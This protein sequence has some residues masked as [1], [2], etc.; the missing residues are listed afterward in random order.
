[1]PEL[2]FEDHS[3]EVQ[4]ILGRIPKWIVRWGI[5]VLFSLVAIILVGGYF[6]PYPEKVVLPVKITT[7]NAPAPIVAQ[8]NSSRLAQWLVEDQ[9]IIE[10]GDLIGIWE[11][12]DNYY[13]VQLL[14]AAIKE[15]PFYKIVDTL[16]LPSFELEIRNHTTSCEQFALI[17][18]SNKHLREIDQLNKELT[19][20][21]E[22]LGLLR[23]QKQVKDREY[24]LL[25]KQFQQDSIYYY[26]GGYG[27][28][29][30]DYE[31]AL[32]LFLQQKSSYFQY[33]ASLVELS[34]SL[35]D[36]ENNITLVKEKREEQI[37]SAKAAIEEALFQIHTKIQDWE[38]ENL[39]VSPISG[40]LDRSQF[41]SKNQLITNGDV[42]AMVIP[43]DPIEIICR[44]IA[45]VQSIS[46]LKEGQRVLM[47][48][49]GFNAQQFGSVEGTINSIS[50]IPYG[51]DYQV[52]INLT[53]KL[54][55][56][57]NVEIPLIQGLTGIAEVVIDES[58]LINKLLNFKN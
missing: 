5:S 31:N 30:R 24:G 11:T 10:K 27:I 4:E 20:K 42:I 50:T 55:T 17:Q 34:N 32:M 57:D 41:W 22:Y 8:R 45:N 26:D 28:I 52:K 58:R 15:R 51:E 2:R 7:L 38:L 6:I 1:M 49:D 25:E 46:K 21:T 35:N 18:N 29:K 16:N 39:M 43:E 33:Q 23:K 13:H 40:R 44:A 36:L 3:E 56:M 53:N 54:V 48:L 19:Q 14:L 9:Q 47:K 12:K 37:T